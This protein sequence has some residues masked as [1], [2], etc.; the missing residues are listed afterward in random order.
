MTL[1]RHV[2]INGYPISSSC[3]MRGDANQSDFHFRVYIPRKFHFFVCTL[4]SLYPSFLLHVMAPPYR[5]VSLRVGFNRDAH[6]NT[7]FLPLPLTFPTYRV[8]Y[9]PRILTSRRFVGARK[10][11][12]QS[13][14]SSIF[15]P[16]L[17]L[18]L[19]THSSLPS[20]V[21]LNLVGL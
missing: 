7:M 5:Y 18:P 9:S 17:P 6:T 8:A 2:L 10:S 3:S 14:G 21:A 16:P 1:F 20:R 15:V 4:S 13:T 19:P 12:D 11:Q